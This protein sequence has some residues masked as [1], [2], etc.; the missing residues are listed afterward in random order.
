MTYWVLEAS[1]AVTENVQDEE[2]LTGD[3]MWKDKA[4]KGLKPKGQ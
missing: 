1:G 2:S 3:K 4:R